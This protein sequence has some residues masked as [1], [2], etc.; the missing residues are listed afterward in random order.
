[1]M[2]KLIKFLLT[3]ALLFSTQ[4]YSQGKITTPGGTFNESVPAGS[5]DFYSVL[6]RAKQSGNTTINF[7]GSDPT[8]I[9]AIQQQAAEMGIKVN[10]NPPTGSPISSSSPSSGTSAAA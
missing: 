6:I 8:A 9:Q 10:V 7:T 2:K 4:I 5:N 1:M 3:F